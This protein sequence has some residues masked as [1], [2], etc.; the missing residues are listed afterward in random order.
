MCLAT[1][2]YVYMQYLL[3]FLVWFNNS[4]QFQIYIVTR[5][6]SSCLLLCTLGGTLGHI[7]THPYLALT[8]CKL[9]LLSAGS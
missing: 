9:G 7:Y 8:P 4:D 5:S 3:L 6:Y 2:A 1:T